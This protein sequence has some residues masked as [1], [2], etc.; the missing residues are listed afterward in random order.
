LILGWISN[1]IFTHAI[2]EKTFINV[3]DDSSLILTRID[4]LLSNSGSCANIIVKDINGRDIKPLFSRNDNDN[5]GTY[6]LDK[7]NR[8]TY[9]LN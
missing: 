4:N 5:D 2:I 9:I 3:Q 8:I 7:R 1:Y 6:A